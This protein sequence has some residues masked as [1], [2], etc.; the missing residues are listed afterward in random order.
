[1]QRSLAMVVLSCKVCY[2]DSMKN[3]Y[4][5]DVRDFYKYDLLLDLVQDYEQL[6]NV[7]MLT[8][9]DQT[10][11]GRKRGYSVGDRRADLHAF[12]ATHNDVKNLPKLFTGRGFTYNHYDRPFAHEGREDYFCSIP[13]GWLQ[14]AV[15]FCD[16]DIGLE[17]DRAYS[18]KAPTK[19]IW[20]KEAAELLGRIKDSC[21]VIYQHL[22]PD[23]NKREQQMTAKVARLEQELN[24]PVSAT[25]EGDVAFLT[26]RQ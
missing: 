10:G 17:D 9:N 8:P 7:I 21:L 25:R 20:F 2:A 11:E 1:M 12:L 24:L 13:D 23:A 14:N 26:I 6:T 4:A 15:V 16:P 18:R 5:G 3:Q 22:T 19:Y